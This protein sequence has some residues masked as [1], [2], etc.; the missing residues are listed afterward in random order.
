MYEKKEVKMCLTILINWQYNIYITW[1]KHLL[2][3]L[4]KNLFAQKDI[5]NDRQIEWD[6][7]KAIAIISMIIIHSVAYS[8]FNPPLDF[9][10]LNYIIFFIL[11]LCAPVFMVAMGFGMAY[12]RKQ[13][14]KVFIKRGIVLLLWGLLINIMYFL[15]DYS[16]GLSLYHSSVSLLCNDVLQ[17]AGL[18][19]ILI[20]IFKAL[21]LNIDRKED[22]NAR[23]YYGI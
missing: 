18:A 12:T 20:G 14:S 16:G 9:S 8:T 19:F 23:C 17:F 10:S 22:G 21:K 6:I 11:G 2:V 15:A 7:A 13:S 5:N 3:F 1:T 4:S